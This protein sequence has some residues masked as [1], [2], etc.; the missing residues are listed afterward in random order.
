MSAEG[1]T[2]NYSYVKFTYFNKT[3]FSIDSFLSLPQYTSPRISNYR[4][5]ISLIS[6]DLVMKEINALLTFAILVIIGVEVEG[7]S[8]FDNETNKKKTKNIKNVK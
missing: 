8:K 4:L 2:A 3:L 1:V 7:Q 5:G 6:H